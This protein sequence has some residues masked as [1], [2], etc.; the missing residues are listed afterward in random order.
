MIHFISFTFLLLF[1][2]SPLFSFTTT[3]AG[4]FSSLLLC[5]VQLSYFFLNL[6]HLIL[7][8]ALPLDEWVGISAQA[9]RLFHCEEMKDKKTGRIFSKLH[10]IFV[11]N[12][13]SLFAHLLFLFLRQKTTKKNTFFFYFFL[14]MLQN[15]ILSYPSCSPPLPPPLCS[16]LPGRDAVVSYP[17]TPF[18]SSPWLSCLLVTGYYFLVTFF[19]FFSIFFSL[20]RVVL[21]NERL[22]CAVHWYRAVPVLCLEFLLWV[23]GFNRMV[24]AAF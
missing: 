7:P 15:E 17:F 12:V 14:F 24:V 10:T 23:G 6:P 11:V 16:R 3:M 2:T 19:H 9:G 18:C 1:S 5:F 20:L 13:F 21:L 22:S 8:T 4:N